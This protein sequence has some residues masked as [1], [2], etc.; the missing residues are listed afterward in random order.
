MLQ[1]GNSS[2]KLI[3]IMILIVSMV[4]ALSSC[5]GFSDWG[6]ILPGNYAIMRVN[7]QSVVFGYLEYE[8]DNIDF[9]T[10]LER[11][12]YGFSYNDSY[13]ALMRLPIEEDESEIVDIETLDLSNMEY[14]L[15][16]LSIRDVSGPYTSQKYKEICDKY[17]IIGLDDW[18]LCKDL[19]PDKIPNEKLF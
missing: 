8:D 15:V 19:T 2:F 10:L 17:E 11:Y 13:I 7:S 14:Y 1:N 4:F 9:D 12:I 6:Y 16:D 3:L 18:I 5:P